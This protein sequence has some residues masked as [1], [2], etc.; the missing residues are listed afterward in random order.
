MLIIFNGS[1]MRVTLR[2]TMSDDP[3]PN[4]T[5]LC[6][7]VYF[8]IIRAFVIFI[9]IIVVTLK[10]MNEVWELKTIIEAVIKVIN[11]ELLGSN[12]VLFRQLF[13]LDLA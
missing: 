11:K 7:S 2:T 13:G 6:V 8:A 12:E 10:T 1:N 4:F 3:K 9:I 5:F